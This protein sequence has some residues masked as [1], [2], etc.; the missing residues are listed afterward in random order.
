MLGIS[1]QNKAETIAIEQGLTENSFYEHHSI[2][3]LLHCNEYICTCHR[4]IVSSNQNKVLRAHY[5][6][7]TFIGDN[8]Y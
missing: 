7:Y 2:K 8:I 6:L 5:V 4:N 1:R 3:L